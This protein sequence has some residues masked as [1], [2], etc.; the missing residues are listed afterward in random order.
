MHQ[1]VVVRDFSVR[2][3]IWFMQMFFQLYLF[4]LQTIAKFISANA[5]KKIISGRRL[6]P[7]LTFV[8][9][10][11]LQSEKVMICSTL[12]N[13]IRESHAVNIPPLRRRPKLLVHNILKFMKNS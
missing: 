12:T 9:S 8:K 13:R 5:Q 6:R 3:R 1:A 4:P 10:S 2:H 7:D 11:S